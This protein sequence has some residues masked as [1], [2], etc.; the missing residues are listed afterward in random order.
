MRRS[1]R[2]RLEQALGGE[3]I[4]AHVVRED[5]AE[6]AHARLR[7]EMEDTVEAGQVENVV[8]Q[9]EPQ[10]L[11]AADVLLLQLRVVVVAEAVDPDHVVPRVGECVGKV[12]ADEARSA[13]HG[14]SHLLSLSETR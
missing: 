12:R 11:E 1:A 8:G 13:R 10:H 14:V 3:H 6:A 2:S 7:G 5:V 9:V 4:V